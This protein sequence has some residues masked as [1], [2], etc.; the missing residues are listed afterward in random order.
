[1]EIFEVTILYPSTKT[2]TVFVQGNDT[3]KLIKLQIEDKCGINPEA[4][5]LYLHETCLDNQLLSTYNITNKTIL[6]LKVDL[7][8]LLPRPELAMIQESVLQQV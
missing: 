8:K 1:M 6:I 4:M 2:D 5:S 3:Q 7:T